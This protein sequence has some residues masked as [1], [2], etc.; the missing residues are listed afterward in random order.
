[1]GTAISFNTNVQLPRFGDFAVMSLQSHSRRAP[2]QTHNHGNASPETEQAATRPAK[3]IQQL[4]ELLGD[5]ISSPG[6]MDYL[7]EHEITVEGSYFAHP[8]L[9]SSEVHRLKRIGN[10]VDELMDK[11]D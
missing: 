8:D 10:A 2:I 11:I 3:R 5:P 9:T 7:A 4:R 6:A 1:M